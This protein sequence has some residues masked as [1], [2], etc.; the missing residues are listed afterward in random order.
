MLSILT[1][2]IPLLYS[3]KELFFNQQVKKLTREA[4]L[5]LNTIRK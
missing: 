1:F 5:K 4:D 2:D 3:Y